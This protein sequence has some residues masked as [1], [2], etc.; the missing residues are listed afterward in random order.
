MS[1]QS[2]S[3]GIEIEQMTLILAQR[4]PLE[5]LL[6]RTV[7]SKFTGEMVTYIKKTPNVLMDDDTV[8][9]I[10]YWLHCQVKRNCFNEIRYNEVCPFSLI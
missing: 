8:Q 3:L 5:Q 6:S 2:M 4:I 9:Y 10:K 1:K 7:K